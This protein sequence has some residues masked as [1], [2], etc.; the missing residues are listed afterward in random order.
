M[1]KEYHYLLVYSLTVIEWPLLV[2]IA[3]DLDMRL[4]YLLLLCNSF[5]IQSSSQEMKVC[6]L[7]NLGRQSRPL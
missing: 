6:N 5:L 3:K 4:R 2:D 7:L 1:G